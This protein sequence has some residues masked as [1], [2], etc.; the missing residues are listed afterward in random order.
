MFKMLVSFWGAYKQIILNGISAFPDEKY[1]S[2]IV[3]ATSVSH[4]I[5]LSVHKKI[6]IWVFQKVE[7]ICWGV[8]Q[9]IKKVI[10]LEIV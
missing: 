1:C 7:G 8:P 4:R 6:Y 10:S 5:F 9:G 3:N 2:A